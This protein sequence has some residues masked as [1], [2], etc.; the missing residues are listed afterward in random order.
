MSLLSLPTELLDAIVEQLP[1]RRWSL[2]SKRLR[3]IAQKYLFRS[4]T[5]EA[6]HQTRHL[7]AFFVF[8]QDCPHIASY[9]RCLCI[10]SHGYW[11]YRSDVPA[12]LLICV[13]HLAHNLDR[14]YLTGVDI[15]SK[16]PP[17][18]VSD[19]LLLQLPLKL[20]RIRLFAIYCH[21]GATLKGFLELMQSL[22]K[23]EEMVFNTLPFTRTQIH[24]THEEGR[25]KRHPADGAFFL[26]HFKLSLD[27]T[28]LVFSPHAEYKDHTVICLLRHLIQ[29]SSVRNLTSLIVACH[30]PEAVVEIGEFLR[31][32]GGGLV[33]LDLDL[34]DFHYYTG[35][36]RRALCKCQD[37]ILWNE[38]T[39]LTLEPTVRRSE[40]QK[41]SLASCLSLE[42]ITLHGL[43]GLH[44]HPYH[45][46]TQCAKAAAFPLFLDILSSATAT[47]VQQITF[48][49]FSDDCRLRVTE[50]DLIR[51]SLE[52]NATRINWS[53]LRRI[54]GGLLELKAF[55]LVLSI[56]NYQQR[57]TKLLES[58]F[59]KG[60][61]RELSFWGGS[62]VLKVEAANE[63]VKLRSTSP[64][65]YSECCVR[66]DVHHDFE[67]C[68]TS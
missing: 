23:V 44:V 29:S 9:V 50:S 24:A 57:Q 39:M 43:L 66:R 32:S 17:A 61:K 49:L 37:L 42:S 21:V 67:H 65:R 7:E 36:P 59:Q 22:V 47:N 12:I 45:K 3:P 52:D 25:L 16:S 60:C 68:G 53:Q 11:Q 38:G 5:L 46:T 64:R 19:P 1:T 28:K 2:V 54:L 35:K 4:L 10:E 63:Y 6:E 41:L 31:H 14:I 55:H 26:E 48:H 13:I 8:L 62:K 56:E 51:W 40:W 30:T 58:N 18:S 15:V 34:S 20:H 27:A 33:S